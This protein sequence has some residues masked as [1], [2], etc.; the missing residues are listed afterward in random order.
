MYVANSAL[1]NR[2]AKILRYISVMNVCKTLKV[3]AIVYDQNKYLLTLASLDAKGREIK[4]IRSR[5]SAM[6]KNTEIVSEICE[7]IIVLY[8][9]IMRA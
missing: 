5:L 3:I 6:F 2:N 1:A 9:S 8:D 7:I 4:Q